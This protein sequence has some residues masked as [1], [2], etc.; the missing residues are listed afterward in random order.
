M[1]VSQCAKSSRDLT[2]V[3][4]AKGVGEE[5]ERINAEPGA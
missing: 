5:I 1:S 4:D 3:A 2:N